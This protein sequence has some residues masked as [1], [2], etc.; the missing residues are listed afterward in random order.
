MADLGIFL[1]QLWLREDDKYKIRVLNGPIN[2]TARPR[3]NLVYQRSKNAQLY[4]RK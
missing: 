1:L 2:L 3:Y 4:S